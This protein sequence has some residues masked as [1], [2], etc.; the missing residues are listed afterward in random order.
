MK[1]YYLIL[2]PF[3]LLPHFMANFL[4][5]CLGSLYYWIDKK[6][7]IEVQERIQKCL[8]VSDTKKIELAKEF[9][10]SF[11]VF[12]IEMTRLP[13]H[14]KKSIHKIV[15]NSEHEKIQNILKEGNGCILVTGHFGNW[16]Y[17]GM[18]FALMGLPI[19]AVSKPLK[20]SSLDRFLTHCRQKNGIKTI[21]QKDAYREMLRALKKNE[22]VVLLLDFETS[23]EK[24][25]IFV[26]FFGEMAASIPTAAMV[27]LK[28]NA[29]IIVAR[30]RRS[31]DLTTSYTDIDQIIYGS[32]A[33]T[34]EEKIVDITRKINES[35]ERFIVA[36]PPEWLWLQ[37]RWRFPYE[38]KLLS[39]NNKE[40]SI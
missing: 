38:K 16:E 20:I 25:G 37:R 39:E 35:Y 4:G 17:A 33:Q 29:P 5:K 18:A 19:N 2:F 34:K 36:C 3:S 32:D 7:R 30:N 13:F 22:I 26:P 12:V 8:K 40:D 14:N 9:Y 11:G 21:H 10:R 27:H 31:P 28:T 15:T 6:H 1:V 24:G 23:P